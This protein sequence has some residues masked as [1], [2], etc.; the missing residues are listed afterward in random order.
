MIGSWNPISTS[1]MFAPRRAKKQMKFLVRSE[2]QGKRLKLVF[3]LSHSKSADLCVCFV[4]S[5]SAQVNKCREETRNYSTRG[6]VSSQR[7]ERLYLFVEWEKGNF[8]QTTS[9]AYDTAFGAKRV[10]KYN[11]KLSKNLNSRRTCQ[12]NLTLW[13]LAL[14]P[15]KEFYPIFSQF[16]EHGLYDFEW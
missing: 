7:A 13:S 12:N 14:H 3:S 4:A 2:P 15:I 1:A 8:V 10:W 5:R 16:G 11:N 9:F 6:C